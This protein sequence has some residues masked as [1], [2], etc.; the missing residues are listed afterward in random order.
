ME[1]ENIKIYKGP[2]LYNCYWMALIHIVK[3]WGVDENDLLLNIV[4][5]LKI[6]ERGNIRYAIHTI[7]PF[8][9]WLSGYGIVEEE[10]SGEHLYEYLCQ[11]I[12]C[13]IPVIVFVDCFYID[14]IGDSYN[15]IH[16]K[17]CLV[18]YGYE[19]NNLKVI[20]HDYHTSLQY[21]T[22]EVPYNVIYNGYINNS[23]GAKAIAY[24]KT[25]NIQPLETLILG[26]LKNITQYFNKTSWIEDVVESMQE[27]K[28]KGLLIDNQII[29]QAYQ[30][31]MG[32][33]GFQNIITPFL[34]DN[35]N[36]R[37]ESFC[38]DYLILRACYY[39]ICNTEKYK[40]PTFVEK[41]A[42]L[43][44][45]CCESA[46]KWYELFVGEI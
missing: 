25:I 46:K 19:G 11:N 9:E 37:L 39:K 17:H 38:S 7:V 31:G 44:Q 27:M 10:Y 35:C 40:A 34:S 36:E 14:Y 43:N 15:K 33:I 42:I 29:E 18:V 12:D 6:D 22:R 5:I 30:F 13:Q 26:R 20:D 21:K 28:K 8:E 1:I 16:N 41:T 23:E 4:P 2:Y 45:K 32:L 3:T 24:R